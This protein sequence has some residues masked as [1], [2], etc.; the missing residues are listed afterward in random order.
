MEDRVSVPDL[1]A[2]ILHQ[3]G[4]D[5]TRLSFLHKGRQ[6]RLTDPGVTQARVVSQLLG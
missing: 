3:L 6:E 5:H 4:I 1:H 2:T